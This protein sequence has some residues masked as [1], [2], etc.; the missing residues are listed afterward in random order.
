MAES[1]PAGHGKGQRSAARAIAGL[2]LGPVAAFGAADQAAAETFKVTNTKERGKGS[3]QAA[4]KRANRGDD[5][6]RILFVSG[7]SGDV[8]IR[9]YFSVEE[10]AAITTRSKRVDL[11]GRGPYAELAFRDCVVSGRADTHSLRGLDLVD[12][13]IYADCPLKIRGSTITG[14]EASDSG[15]ASDHDGVYSY[16]CLLYTSPSPR[17]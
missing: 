4:V 12:L 8:T 14:T 9:G 1:Q 3:F 17:D 13:E 11:V 5:R 15:D 7:L 16:T 6:D 10:V 2:L